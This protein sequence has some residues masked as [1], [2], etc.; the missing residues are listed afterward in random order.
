VFGAAFGVLYG[1]LGVGRLG[2]QSQDAL[3]GDVQYM[4]WVLPLAAIAGSLL[5]VPRVA[6]VGPGSGRVLLC[7]GVVAATAGILGD[8]VA[9]LSREGVL[10]QRSAANAYFANLRSE[11]PELSSRSVGVMPLSA[12]GVV[13]QPFIYPYGRLDVLLPLLVPGIHVGELDAGEAPVVIDA[14]GQLQPAAVAVD[15]TLVGPG[16]DSANVVAVGETVTLSAEGSCYSDASTEGYLN[17]RSPVSVQGTT[18]MVEMSYEAAGATTVRFTTITAT[19]SR[20]NSEL[21]SLEEGSHTAVFALDGGRLTTLQISG[22][23]RRDEVCLRSLLIV[24]PVVVSPNGTCLI[25]DEYG[26][27]GEAVNC[28]VALTRVRAGRKG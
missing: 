25:V 9:S 4:V 19:S 15:A 7:V 8:G 12:G 28:P 16:T 26:D 17:V 14:S 13:A 2:I 6:L 22:L 21:S 3:A 27:L 20:I 1:F 23:A 5:V 18:L 24:H 10:A 11:I